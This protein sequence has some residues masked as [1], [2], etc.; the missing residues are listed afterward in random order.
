ML[1]DFNECVFRDYIIYMKELLQSVSLESE[2]NSDN[3]N[4]THNSSETSKTKSIKKLGS[5]VNVEHLIHL[6]KEHRKKLT[7]EERN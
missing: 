1:F 7:K 3:N 6:Q 4:S 2:P 5:K